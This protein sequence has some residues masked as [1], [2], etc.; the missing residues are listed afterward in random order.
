MYTSNLNPAK[1]KAW[2][3]L[4]V[5]HLYTKMKGFASHSW[6]FDAYLGSKIY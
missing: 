3:E 4:E 1:Q 5:L 2:E 6:K